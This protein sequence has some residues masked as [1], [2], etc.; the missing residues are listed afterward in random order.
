MLLSASAYQCQILELKLDYL[1]N[2]VSCHDV[3]CLCVCG[4]ALTMTV[5][6]TG[7]EASSIDFPLIVP[8]TRYFSTSQ[9]SVCSIFRVFQVDRGNEIKGRFLKGALVTEQSNC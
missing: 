7:I 5:V 1:N 8:F 6:L 4:F 9:I 2:V 3:L